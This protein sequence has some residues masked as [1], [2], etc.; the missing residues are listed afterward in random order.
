MVLTSGTL[1][2]GPVFRFFSESSLSSYPSLSNT[3]PLFQH[4]LPPPASETL[5]ALLVDF[6]LQLRS[7]SLGDSR[8]FSTVGR[9]SVDCSWSCITPFPILRLLGLSYDVFDHSPRILL[10]SLIFLRLKTLFPVLR[11]IRHCASLPIRLPLSCD[12]LVPLIVVP[13][14]NL[15]RSSVRPA[16]EWPTPVPLL[17]GCLR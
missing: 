5:S 11:D 8:C 15:K 16:A 3:I 4:Q 6:F 14:S 1:P 10:R 17:R 13:P 9:P 12:L 2:S 7:C